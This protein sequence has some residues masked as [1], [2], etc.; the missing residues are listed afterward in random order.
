MVTHL[1]RQIAKLGVDLRLG[2]APTVAEI[3]ALAP[4]HVI[5]ATGSAPSAEIVGNLARG[6]W[7]T[8]GLDLDHVLNVWD[9][10][11]ARRDGR[12]QRAGRRRRRRGMESD[13]A[14]AAARPTTG[15][16]CNSAAPLPFV[17]AKIGPFSRNRLIPRIFASGIRTR[18]FA[19]HRLGD[20][21]AVTISERGREIVVEEIDSVILAGW[22]RPVADLYFE[23][24]AVGVPVDRVGDAVASRTTFE[25]VHEGERAARRI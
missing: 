16:R 2:W 20:S 10:P 21:S 7:D 8:P 14:R 6:V 4:D 23:C 24:K 15:T 19:S 22:H 9:V 5:I 1:E 17:A 3:T 18:E 13:R 12:A 25:A 11:R